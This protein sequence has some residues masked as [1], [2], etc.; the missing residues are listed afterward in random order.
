MEKTKKKRINFLDVLIVLVIILAI[1]AFFLRG[2]LLAF[3]EEVLKVFRK[4]RGVDLR[5]L[6]ISTFCHLRI[7]LGEGYRF[8][9]VV[10]I[11]LAIER[12]VEASVAYISFLE[13]LG[14]KIDCRATAQ[15]EFLFCHN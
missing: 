9:E 11:F 13:L 8:T 5:G 4:F 1:T 14:G 6:G 12:V 7:E 15:D 2:K 3:F 10:L